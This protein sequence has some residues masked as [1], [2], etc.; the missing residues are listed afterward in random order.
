M[1]GML[2]IINASADD[3]DK[4]TEAVDNA[5]GASQRMADTMLDNLSGKFTLFQS[6]LDGVKISLG[7]RVSPYLVTA[8]DWITAKMPDVEHVL[9]RGMDTVD[10]FVDGAKDKISSFT[11]TSEWEDAN[12]FGKMHIAWDSLFGDPLADWWSGIEGTIQDKATQIGT[13]IG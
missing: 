11:S 3:W 6:A 9:M 1:A 10:N 7:E 8:L 2:A 13:V 12:I 4:L 5:D